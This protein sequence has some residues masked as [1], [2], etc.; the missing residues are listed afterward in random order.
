MILRMS[1][2]SAEEKIIPRKGFQDVGTVLDPDLRFFF[3]S[4]DFYHGPVLHVSVS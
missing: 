2:F 1:L 3:P 4:E